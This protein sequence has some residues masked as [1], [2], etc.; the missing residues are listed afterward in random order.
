MTTYRSLSTLN[1]GQENTQ[2]IRV[3][4]LRRWKIKLSSPRL[5]NLKLILVDS[6]GKKIQATIPHECVL[7][8]VD[9]LQDQNWYSIKDFKIKTNVGRTMTTNNTFKLKFTISTIV[10]PI[11]SESSSLYFYPSSFVDI[12]HRRLDF[13]IVVDVI[14]LLVS[15]APIQFCFNEESK[16]NDIAFLSFKIED[17]REHIIECQAVGDTAVQFEENRVRCQQSGDPEICLL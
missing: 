6:E 14:G 3:K 1:P 5:Y 16:I 4:L 11:P 9:D 13:Q 10:K 2:L 17:D 8:F 12:I 7:Y 15:S